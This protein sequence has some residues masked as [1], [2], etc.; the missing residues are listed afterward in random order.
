MTT[1]D[2]VL[3]TIIWGFNAVMLARPARTIY[4][5]RRYGGPDGYRIARFNRAFERFKCL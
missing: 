3:L 2:I 5:H 1:W 4:I